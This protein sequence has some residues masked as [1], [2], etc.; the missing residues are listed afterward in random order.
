MPVNNIEQIETL[1]KLDKGVLSAAIANE[2]GVDVSV[3]GLVVRSSAD[4]ELREATIKKEGQTIGAEIGRKEVFKSMGLD[5][6]G[7]GAH[8]TVEKSVEFLN[9]HITSK[10]DELGKEPDKRIIELNKDLEI[11]KGNYET[12]KQANESL[13]S[14]ILNL[15]NTT[16]KNTAIG[17]VIPNA[18]NLIIPQKAFTTLFNSENPSDVREGKVVYLDASGDVRKNTESLQPLTS[19]EVMEEFKPAYLKAAGGGGGGGHQVPKGTGTIEAFEK[20]MSEKGV[21]VGSEE[22][23]TELNKRVENKTINI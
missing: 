5:I 3:E 8:K 2:E 10:V 17:S 14:K 4:N 18:E 6:E 7:T 20:E 16:V 1:L 23:N 21:N 12:S 11:M 15:E 13:S 22:F 9:N 19:G